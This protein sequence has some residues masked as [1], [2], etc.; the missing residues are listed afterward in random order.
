MVRTRLLIMISFT[1]KCMPIIYTPHSE[2]TILIVTAMLRYGLY[3]LYHL[4]QRSYADF[5]IL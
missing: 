5:H 3:L 1:W 4:P 2:S